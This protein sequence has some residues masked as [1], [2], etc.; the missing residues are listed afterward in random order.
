MDQKKK[1]KKEKECYT[2]TKRKINKYTIEDFQLNL[3][4]ETWEQVFDGNYV[5]EIF[6]SFF[7]YFPKNLLF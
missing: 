6:N 2:Y 1:K 3:R 7:K 5:N 4:Y